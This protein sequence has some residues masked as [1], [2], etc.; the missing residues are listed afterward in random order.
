M[1][2]DLK[3]IEDATYQFLTTK[4]EESLTEEKIQLGV[5]SILDVYHPGVHLDDNDLSQIVRRLMQRLEIDM[6]IGE[7]FA[8]IA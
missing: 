8:A 6:V 1:N 2:I 3:L 4:D 5:L 7:F